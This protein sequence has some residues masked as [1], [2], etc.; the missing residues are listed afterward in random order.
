MIDIGSELRRE[1]DAIEDRPNA[2]LELN[3]AHERRGRRRRL[4]GL[5]VGVALLAALGV[6]AK[7][8]F[9]APHSSVR[10]AASMSPTDCLSPPPDAISCDEAMVAASQEVGTPESRDA[11]SVDIQLGSYRASPDSEAIVSWI[12][13]Y[14]EAVQALHGGVFFEGDSCFRG[15]LVIA[16]DA[17]GGSVLNVSGS[18]NPT[19]CSSPGGVS[20]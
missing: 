2:L 1:A 3:A 6:M 16:V 17:S 5:V 10:T 7:L 18:G 8:V 4:Q 13:T 12:V 9:T 19:P 20:H 11:A 15:D 14:A